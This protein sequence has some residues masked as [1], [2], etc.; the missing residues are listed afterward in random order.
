MA[1][2]HAHLKIDTFTHKENRVFAMHPS[3]SHYSE[4]ELFLLMQQGSEAAYAVLYQRYLDLL[5]SAAFLILDH[6]DAAKDVAQ[7][8]LISLWAKHATLRINTNLKAYLLG[9]VRNRCATVLREKASRD[10]RQQIYASLSN[11]ITGAPPLETKELGQQLHAAL[12][13]VSPV[14]RKVFIMSY[15]EKKQMKEIASELNIKL[16]T[17]KNH[18]QQALKTLRQH[19][20]K[21]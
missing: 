2:T 19:L 12:A 18:M 15:I 16:Q 8:V 21:N 7:E 4:D 14:G 10:N 3:L 6:E 13:M 20:R 9:A 17:A 11:T 1:L 5:F